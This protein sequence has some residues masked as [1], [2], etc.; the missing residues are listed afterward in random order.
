M[1]A[2]PRMVASGSLIGPPGGDGEPGLPGVNALDNDAAVAAYLTAP[3]SA[4]Y[5]AADAATAAQVADPA[6]A[7]R[8]ALATDFAAKATQTTVDSGR[9]SAASVTAETRTQIADRAALPAHVATRTRTNPFD[10]VRGVYNW[11]PSNTRRLR[12]GLGKAIRGGITQHVVVGDSMAAGAVYGIAGADPLVFDR[13][14]AWPMIMR[15]RLAN[16]GVPECGSG[17]IRVN[18]NALGS[19]LWWALSGAPA[20][21]LTAKFYAFTT[22]AAV[23]TFTVPAEHAGATAYSHMWVDPG[24]GGGTYPFTISVNGA[25]SGAGYRAVTSTTGVNRLR[26]TTLLLAAPLAA[27]DTIVITGG[28][29]GHYFVGG[30]VWNPATGGLNVH[31]LAQSGSRAYASGT[32]QSDRWA[33]TGLNSL[34]TLLNG[35]MPNGTTAWATRTVTDAVFVAADNTVTSATAAF[36]DDDLGRTIT[37]PAG[38]SGLRLPGAGNCYITAINSATSVEVSQAPLLSAT[39]VSI[40]IGQTPDVL[41]IS[42]GANDLSNGIS[43]A[44]IAAAI[45]AIRALMP[46]ADVILYANPQPAAAIIA[47]ATYDSWV[48]SLYDLADTLDVPFF[49]LRARFGTFTQW[50]GDGLA[51]DGLAH[52]NSSL[53]AE[54]GMAVASLMAS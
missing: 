48:S 22:G 19:P 42:I 24:L 31:N 30:Q 54:W 15:D 39:G 6:S 25:V 18:D 11:K 47:N 37:T 51:G 14:G 26:V 49:D 4:T 52:A 13:A 43:N 53:F 3:A 21:N 41:H 27:G 38:T 45:T 2:F 46:T 32:G 5:A 7:T 16:L 44:N 36:T 20:W 29:N 23:A 34:G 1:T 33:S 40:T 8:D 28:A 12:T 17:W 35:A 9:L 50:S 10:A